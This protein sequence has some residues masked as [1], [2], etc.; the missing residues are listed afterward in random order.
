MEITG[1]PRGATVTELKTDERAAEIAALKPGHWTWNPYNWHSVVGFLRH[2]PW[3]STVVEILE[4]NMDHDMRLLAYKRPDGKLVFVV[5]NRSWKDYT[6]NINT[7]L[8]NATFS[9]YRYTPDKTGED[10]IGV[11]VGTVEG[12]AVAVTVPDLA[13]EFWVEQ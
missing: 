13:W 3:D 10:F 2:M 7:G 8:S 1:L 4:E 12:G 11:P 6:F 9:G 5:S